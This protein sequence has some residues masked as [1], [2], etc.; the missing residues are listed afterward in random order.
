MYVVVQEEKIPKVMFG[1][2]ISSLEGVLYKGMYLQNGTHNWDIR[3]I[4]NLFLQ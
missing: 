4:V 2:N 1:M 3:D